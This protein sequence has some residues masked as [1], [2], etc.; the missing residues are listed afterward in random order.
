MFKKVNGGS[1]S[2]PP[3][4]RFCFP[5]TPIYLQRILLQ[6]ICVGE[7]EL[8]QQKYC[9]VWKA[10]GLSDMQQLHVLASTVSMLNHNPVNYGVLRWVIYFTSLKCQCWPQLSH[11]ASHYGMP[12]LFWMA[13]LNN[14][15][16][17]S[18]QFEFQTNNRGK[19]C[20]KCSLCSYNECFPC[21]LC[22]AISEFSWNQYSADLR[23]Y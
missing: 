11:S 6:Y 3:F 10:M 4:G 5:I 7:A 2:T 14:Q 21:F 19:N 9:Q 18:K 1:I 20:P 12:S 17:V 23:V 13:V 8:S 15:G 16:L 22:L